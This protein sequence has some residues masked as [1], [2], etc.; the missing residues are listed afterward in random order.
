MAGSE[1][2]I[3]AG[4]YWFVQ[5]IVQ[6]AAGYAATAPTMFGGRVEGEGA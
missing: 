3:L 5:R 6:I 4:S 2:V 1:T